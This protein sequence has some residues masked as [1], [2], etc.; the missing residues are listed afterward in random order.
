MF[1]GAALR[2]I[3]SRKPTGFKTVEPS[4]L[5]GAEDEPARKRV[6]VAPPP[7]PALPVLMVPD[8]E[9]VRASREA[10]QNTVAAC[11]AGS[12]SESTKR[13]YESTLSAALPRIE[14]ALGAP[15]LPLDTE[16]RFM[17]FFAAAHHTAAGRSDTPAK[18]SHIK[19]LKA[20]TDY[21]HSN[22]GYHAV[23]ND[24]WTPR[25]G[26]FWQGLKRSCHHKSKEKEALKLQEVV[27]LMQDGKEA[28]DAVPSDPCVF[29]AW[30]HDNKHAIASIRTAA[31]VSI[32]FF[33][34]RRASEVVQ[35][36][37][38]DVTNQPD[39]SI[40]LTIRRQKNDQVGIGQLSTIPPF[41]TRPDACPVK[42][43]GYW[44]TIRDLLRVACDR[45][46]RLAP[47]ADLDP[48]KSATKDPLF[49]NLRG[50]RWGFAL[51]TESLNSAMRSHFNR[52]VSPR[53]GGTQFYLQHAAPRAAVQSQG[54][55][56][57]QATMD[58]VYARFASDNVA[59]EV[60]QAASRG[61]NDLKVANF[62]ADL[63]Q[64]PEALHFID[65]LE[66]ETEARKW[67]IRLGILKP[68]LTPRRVHHEVPEFITQI[69]Q[70]RRALTT[71]PSL[72]QHVLSFLNEYRSDLRVFLR[73]FEEQ[74]TA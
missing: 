48:N 6:R 8:S 40:S 4:L 47:Y 46:G 73:D 74:G 32:A 13:T 71:S 31:C 64:P 55:W 25:M 39:G 66:R 63:A 62:L 26:N 61:E 67:V 35:L 58:A 59:T 23:T 65:E 7:P 70:R 14:T 33:G 72:T 22:H 1:L 24:P 16:E 38:S 45:E 43:I 5:L 54:G 29:A 57:S 10:I 3:P 30:A 44:I 9:R 11:L 12:V 34:I 49:V 28:Y 50:P 69:G 42:T 18:W 51:S 27:A 2:V 20:A 56:R 41:R 17:A 53:K 36:A 60:M 15:P 19:M 37:C 21:W 68:Y 52:L